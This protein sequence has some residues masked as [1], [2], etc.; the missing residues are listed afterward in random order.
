MLSST[1]EGLSSPERS[2]RQL[3][4]CSIWVLGTKR[5]C[6]SRATGAPQQLNHLQFH[7]TLF[8]LPSKTE[9]WSPLYNNRPFP[10][11]PSAPGNPILWLCVPHGSHEWINTALVFLR[12]CRELHE[13]KKANSCLYPR[14]DLM[15]PRVWVSPILE[16]VQ[17]KRSPI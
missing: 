13:G 4:G 1:A 15:Y 7:R 11:I 5:G 16:Y 12:L 14:V 2:Y 8:I 9:P 10:F 6:S 17:S 3:C